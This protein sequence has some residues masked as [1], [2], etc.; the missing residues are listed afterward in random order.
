M[1]DDLDFFIFA[2]LESSIAMT[3]TSQTAYDFVM[4]ALCAWKEAQTQGYDGMLAVCWTVK[5]RAAT[6]CWW[7]GPSLSSIVTKPYQF[8]SFNANDPGVGKFPEDSD[9]SWQSALKAADDCISGA[10]QD[11]TGGA[12]YYHDDSI[13]TPSEWGAVVQTAQVGKLTFFKGV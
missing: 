5:N 9:P 12:V 8:S 1:S 7:G 2:S 10:A 6:P 13:P 11:L 3:Y 4:L